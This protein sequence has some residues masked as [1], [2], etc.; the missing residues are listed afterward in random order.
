MDHCCLLF[1]FELV[2]NWKVNCGSSLTPIPNHPGTSYI[3][4]LVAKETAC[5]YGSSPLVISGEPGQI[6]NLTLWDFSWSTRSQWQQPGDGCDVLYGHMFD[7][8]TDDVINIC[9]GGVR[10]KHLYKSTSHQVH[11]VLNE[12]IL[13]EFKFLIQYEGM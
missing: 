12:D 7:V 3:A 6:L 11:L 1:I 9:G 4:S 5:G 2:I 10:M 8:G 13:D